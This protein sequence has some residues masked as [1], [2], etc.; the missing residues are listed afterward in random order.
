MK[1]Y[2]LCLQD[3]EAGKLPEWETLKVG[4]GS[5]ARYEMSVSP[6][7]CWQLRPVDLVPS[8]ARMHVGLSCISCS[9]TVLAVPCIGLSPLCAPAVV[10][11]APSGPILHL[12][13]PEIAKNYWGL[14]HDAGMRELLLAIRADEAG[15]VCS[16]LC[17]RIYSDISVV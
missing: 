2:T 11:A 16:A 9:W 8:V 1:T 4:S 14:S 7:C 6:A 17:R 15:G 5:P 12:Q 13:A 10:F 3:L